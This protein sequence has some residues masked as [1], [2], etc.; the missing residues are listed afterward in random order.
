MNSINLDITENLRI[1]GAT[2]D[3]DVSFDEIIGMI[4]DIL[5]GN[6]HYMKIKYVYL[7]FIVH[8]FMLSIIILK[9]RFL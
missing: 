2:K 5:M 1:S 6:L 9:L 3:E 8:I 4:E 7:F